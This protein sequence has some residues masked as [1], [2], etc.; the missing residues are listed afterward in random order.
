MSSSK[1]YLPVKHTHKEFLKV[2]FDATV[3][4]GYTYDTVYETTKV[5]DGPRHSREDM[6]RS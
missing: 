6:S 3:V 2:I 5:T 4:V 1:F